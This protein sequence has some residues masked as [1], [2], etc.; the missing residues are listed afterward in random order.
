MLY[1]IM[2]GGRDGF[3]TEGGAV[4][5]RVG[6]GEGGQAGQQQQQQHPPVVT[7]LRPTIKAAT[8]AFH[9]LFD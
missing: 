4:V 2:I 8:G 1:R 6:V 5:D 7:K 9:L 3:L